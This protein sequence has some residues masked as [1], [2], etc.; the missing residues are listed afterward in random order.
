MIEF[1]S[2]DIRQ[3]DK[4]LLEMFGAIGSQIG[5]FVE[6]QQANED[7]KAAKDAAEAANRAKSEF[8]AKM[9]H[10]IRTPMNAIIGMTELVL[11]TPL[12]PQQREYLKLV[13]ESGESLL[14]VINDVLDFSKIEAGRVDL[15]QLPLDLRETVGDTMKSLAVRAHAKGLELAYR[16]APNVPQGLVGDRA[17]CGK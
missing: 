14:T 6:R 10:E 7:L 2:R 3:P 17:G 13:Q 4:A 5:L 1:F 15:D 11:D 12:A 16:V 8:L 9:S